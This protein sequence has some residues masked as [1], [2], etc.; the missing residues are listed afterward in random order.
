M[1]E[2]RFEL[3][4]GLT[5]KVLNLAPL[6]TRTPPH[7]Y[8]NHIKLNKINFLLFR[9]D[10][11]F[12][13]FKGKTESLFD[14]KNY[15]GLEYEERRN[16]ITGHTSY[17]SS[18][19]ANR[20]FDPGIRLIENAEYLDNCRFCEKCDEPKLS[21]KDGSITIENKF[22]YRR[23]SLVTIYPPFNFKHKNSLSEIGFDDMERLVN[24]EY[25]IAK[26]IYKKDSVIGIQ[27]ITNWGPESG[28]SQ[29]HPHSQR[30]S[31]S[32]LDSRTEREL[33]LS[34]LL[35]EK[36]NSN[37]FDLYM[38]EERL[39]KER[40]IYDG[41]VFICSDFAPVS[42]DSILI[43]QK[44]NVVNIL[45]MDN[46]QYRNKISR[47]ITGIM[48]AL[49]FYRGMRAFNLKVHM[50]PFSLDSHKYYRYHIHIEPRRLGYP[51]DVGGIEHGSSDSIIS[52]YPEETASVLRE[53]FIEG[54]KPDKYK[55]D[56][57]K[58]IE[59]IKRLKSRS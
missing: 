5:D 10:E 53:C 48:N 29:P 21:H 11:F 38:K 14:T 18:E 15:E 6:A 55:D 49:Y 16:P 3:T 26:N 23:F 25:D 30:S 17:I 1:R 57:K 40:I 42:N 9:M 44:D 33:F 41:D 51:C 13:I 27:D 45:E 43:I 58:E 37:P 59:L 12:I 19:R 28:A 8:R 56:I 52:I 39:K 20:G 35:F 54:P 32:I 36:Y 24:T 47:P 50:S 34:N 31:L 46:E 22:P 4:N 7:H 2:M